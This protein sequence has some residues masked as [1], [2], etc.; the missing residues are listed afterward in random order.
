[1]PA[2]PSAAFNDGAFERFLTSAIA[3]ILTLIFSWQIIIDMEH[4]AVKRLQEGKG[5]DDTLS[6]DDYRNKKRARSEDITRNGFN[7]AALLQKD[8]TQQ[9][10]GKNQD[11]FEDDVF[12][13][14]S[15]VP[16]NKYRTGRWN[17]LHESEANN[18][19][20]RSLS[21]GEAEFL[22]AV[23]KNNELT[24]DEELSSIPAQLPLIQVTPPIGGIKRP[25][26]PYQTYF[27]S[28]SDSDADCELMQYDSN[29]LS[30]L[31]DF[32]MD[33]EDSS[34]S[35][36]DTEVFCRHVLE[37]ISEGDEE[38]YESIS[39]SD[40]DE[41]EE[42]VGDHQ[43][44]SRKCHD[45]RENIG[46]NPRGRVAETKPRHLLPDR[47]PFRNL[48]MNKAHTN[49]KFLTGA[50]S[51][52]VTQEDLMNNSEMSHNL[53]QMKAPRAEEEE[54]LFE[55]AIYMN[56]DFD[57]NECPVEKQTGTHSFITD[58]S[59]NIHRSTPIED[60][61]RSG[62][63]SPGN[64]IH[65]GC[66]SN[67]SYVD[68]DAEMNMSSPFT[69][70][71]ISRAECPADFKRDH[72]G[73]NVSDM[74]DSTRPAG[75]LTSF[76]IGRHDTEVSNGSPGGSTDNAISIGSNLVSTGST[77]TSQV[78]VER[79]LACTESPGLNTI[80]P[81]PSSK[82]HT[83]II[84]RN[85]YLDVK[86][87]SMNR[88]R[89]QG[90]G[91]SEDLNP[92]PF[93]Q[94]GR[95]G[96]LYTD[97][98]LSD[99]TH[100]IP[101]GFTFVRCT[102]YEEDYKV[103]STL[104]FQPRDPGVRL[105]VC[106]PNATEERHQPKVIEV[107]V[108]DI[109]AILSDT[110]KAKA[111]LC[112]DTETRGE[113]VWDDLG[114]FDE[115]TPERTETVHSAPLKFEIY[116]RQPELTAESAQQAVDFEPVIP[117]LRAALNRPVSDNESD[118][119]S[120]S[121]TTGDTAIEVIN[122]KLHVVR[123]G[124]VDS[125]GTD[126]DYVGDILDDTP[127]KM[128]DE[129]S[130][131][132]VKK[133][134]ID[135]DEEEPVF[136]NLAETV[137]SPRFK[138]RRKFKPREDSGQPSVSHNSARII[139]PYHNDKSSTT[140][141]NAYNKG[142]YTPGSG[143]QI[144]GVPD[145][146][147]DH[148]AS[149]GEESGSNSD[150]SG[151]FDC[152]GDSDKSPRGFEKSVPKPKL[153][154]LG[155]IEEE[156]SSESSGEDTTVNDVKRSRNSDTSSTSS[157][158]DSSS[159]SD[160]YADAEENNLVEG[161]RQ[162]IENSSNIPLTQRSGSRD[163]VN[164]TLDGRY[165]SDTIGPQNNTRPKYINEHTHSEDTERKGGIHFGIGLSAN[166]D[167]TDN[168][169]PPQGIAVSTNN[170]ESSTSSSHLDNRNHPKEARVTPLETAIAPPN[171]GDFTAPDFSADDLCAETDEMYLRRSSG[172][173]YS[174][175][176][177]ELLAYGRRPSHGRSEYVSPLVSYTPPA[178]PK[179]EPK[180][181]KY[182][183]TGVQ[184]L[185]S[186]R[187]PNSCTFN[188][189]RYFRPSDV[190][191]ITFTTMVEHHGSNVVEEH[192]YSEKGAQIT[193][194]PLWDREDTQLVASQD[195]LSDE[196]NKSSDSIDAD[197]FHR[198][199]GPSSPAGIPGD[200]S[201]IHAHISPKSRTSS[202]SSSEFDNFEKEIEITAEQ[203]E[204]NF[205]ANEEFTANFKAP[206]SLEED[207][208][209]EIAPKVKVDT[210]EEVMVSSEARVS[211]RDEQM[212]PPS[213]R[214]QSVQRPQTPPLVTGPKRN[215]PSVS[216]DIDI[217]NDVEEP[218]VAAEVKAVESAPPGGESFNLTSNFDADDEGG[219]ESEAENKPSSSLYN[220]FSKPR[221]TTDGSTVKPE[222]PKKPLGLKKPD[223]SPKETE[224]S[225]EKPRVSAK[226]PEI[227]PPK[228][229]T[230]AKPVI[231][232]PVTNVDHP[233]ED[234]KARPKSETDKD[235]NG[236]KEYKSI[237]QKPIAVTPKNI[238]H[239][240]SLPDKIA[241]VDR[242]EI[243]E[244]RQEYMKK[245]AEPGKTN[246]E[247]RKALLSRLLGTRDWS[248]RPK[249]ILKKPSQ[250]FR[251]IDDSKREALSRSLSKSKEN[252]VGVFSKED[253]KDR[254]SAAVER[255]KLEDKSN[256]KRTPLR[257]TVGPIACSKYNEEMLKRKEM[258]KSQ[259][260]PSGFS[261]GSPQIEKE[262]SKS[263]D[264]ILSGR[265]STLP[266]AFSVVLV[267]SPSMTLH[268]TASSFFSDRKSYTNLVETD[269]DTGEVT[270][271]PLVMET[272][273]DEVLRIRQATMPPKCRSLQDLYSQA[274]L[275]SIVKDVY[276]DTGTKEKKTWEKTQS[277]TA[278]T[279]L[280]VSV[281][282][283]DADDE[284]FGDCDEPDAKADTIQ[285]TSSDH[286]MRITKSL[287]KLDLPD[288]YF[289]CPPKP[290]EEK[291]ARE[292]KVPKFHIGESEIANRSRTSS[293]NSSFS[294]GR[295]VVISTRVTMPRTS[296]TAPDDKA[297]YEL[298]SQKIK[299]KLEESSAYKPI[300]SRMGPI[301]AV[302]S[303]S[304]EALAEKELKL[305]ERKR[306]T[307]EFQKQKWEPP[308]I[309]SPK[310][311]RVS[312]A[313]KVRVEPETGE[314]DQEKQQ[315]IDAIADLLVADE[316][317]V[318][319]T[320]PPAEQRFSSNVS[321][322]INSA[323]PPPV[324]K[325]HNSSSESELSFLNS[326]NH[327]NIHNNLDSHF[328]PVHTGSNS[329][330]DSSFSSI[331]PPNFDRALA[332]SSPDL[333]RESPEPIRKFQV[334]TV[335]VA[336]APPKS[337]LNLSVPPDEI[338]SI[339]NIESIVEL[340][341]EIRVEM[342]TYH[343]AAPVHMFDPKPVYRP[344]Q[345]NAVVKP[346][347]E[348]KKVKTKPPPPVRKSSRKEG[349]ISPPLRT[350][351]TRQADRS[352]PLRT[353]S[354]RQADTSPPLRTSSTRQ[355]DRS[356][357]LR[358][359]SRKEAERPTT[360]P[361]QPRSSAME[362]L[363]PQRPAPSRPEIND[364][365]GI[366]EVKVVPQQTAARPQHTPP[367]AP[368]PVFTKPVQPIYYQPNTSRSSES[369]ASITQDISPRYQAPPSSSVAMVKQ[370]PSSPPKVEKKQEKKE[371]KFSFK[372]FKPIVSRKP[373]K[374]KS[375]E[376]PKRHTAE[377][378]KKQRPVAA[379]QQENKAAEPTKAPL[380]MSHPMNTSIESQETPSFRLA[381]A[382]GSR[383]NSYRE[384]PVDY[385]GPAS[386]RSP[387][388]PTG[389][390][391]DSATYPRTEANQ[392]NIRPEV[393]LRR[394]PQSTRTTERPYTEIGHHPNW[395]PAAAEDLRRSFQ[396]PKVNAPKAAIETDSDL[397]LYLSP[398]P[399][400]KKTPTETDLDA[401]GIRRLPARA[402][403]ETDIDSD[404]YDSPIRKKGHG[405]QQVLETN[406]DDDIPSRNSSYKNG[407]SSRNSSFSDREPNRNTSREREPAPSLPPRRY[408]GYQ[409]EPVR[410]PGH[411]PDI[412]PRWDT[413]RNYPEKQ[414]DYGPAPN[415]PPRKTPTIPQPIETDIDA[416]L[417]F[418][419]D[420]SRGRNRQPAY[421]SAPV[422]NNASYYH[423]VPGSRDPSYNQAQVQPKREDAYQKDNQL[424][425]Q[426]RSNQEPPRNKRQQQVPLYYQNHQQSDLF[427]VP[428]IPPREVTKD[429]PPPSIHNV[430]E[431]FE[432]DVDFNL[433]RFETVAV[434]G[435]TDSNTPHGTLTRFGRSQ[436]P[437]PSTQQPRAQVK[438]NHSYDF[439]FEAPSNSFPPT[440]VTASNTSYTTCAVAAPRHVFSV[441]ESRQ[442]QNVPMET[443]EDM[444]FAFVVNKQPKEIDSDVDIL[445]SPRTQ[446][447]RGS[448]EFGPDSFQALGK[449]SD[450][451]VDTNSFRFSKEE[452]QFKC[453]VGFSGATE[454]EATLA[455]VLDGLL[456]LPPSPQGSDARVSSTDS[457]DRGT[458][459]SIPD[460]ANGFFG[461][462][463]ESGE[464]LLSL[465]KRGQNIDEN[466][467]KVKCRNTNCGKEM[468]LA[469]ARCSYKTCH[470]CYT[471]YCCRQ[472]R[473]NDW[474][475]HKTACS[476]N[477][478]VSMCKHAIKTIY[479]DPNILF[480]MSKKAR[481]G[482]LASGRGCILLVF[483]NLF[484]AEQFVREGQAALRLEPVYCSMTELEE[485]YVLGEYGD[486][487]MDMCV[488]YSPYLNFIV[489]VAIVMSKDTRRN[490]G[491]PKKREGPVIKKCAKLCLSASLSES[492]TVSTTSDQ[493]ALI[494]TVG[495]N[496]NSYLSQ[497]EAR[498]ESFDNVQRKLR[499]R[500]VC[501]RE[502][503]PDV[504]NQLIA[505]V[506]ENQAFPQITIYPYD[507]STGSTFMC[508]I[509]LE[510]E[511]VQTEPVCQ[512]TLDTFT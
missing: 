15:T 302:L 385:Q 501:L 153:E 191:S 476:Y 301:D 328:K 382:P 25:L 230:F 243:K 346:M 285:R 429:V 102:D 421:N 263:T 235:E 487:V 477:R 101:R 225:R 347:Q 75:P 52:N 61:S 446:G 234:K 66:H 56:K 205:T 19:G 402:I 248:D 165:G 440:L 499:Q 211:P 383:Q 333:T 449:R 47:A 380:S 24:F 81:S 231:K 287:T 462:I 143:V 186:Y 280:S 116:N 29:K 472:C 42:Q 44:K 86:K 132:R 300:K 358:T 62:E 195:E 458:P 130:L 299:K 224:M 411:I 14:N 255:Q 160:S 340:E 121:T 162:S 430:D 91:E 393:E 151:S 271:K 353:S 464:N 65:L 304:R 409:A 350:S 413:S 182:T 67:V 420:G 129:K 396:G 291:P 247:E 229:P 79:L 59:R 471:Y 183:E 438:S 251:E 434:E 365:A 105:N 43:E 278:L 155:E 510:Q 220:T 64:K 376:T 270:E 169:K 177:E 459:D 320:L 41:D 175:G 316:A 97:S 268:R 503:Y 381:R 378:V 253:V 120:S 480:Q 303:K 466:R 362:R 456:A 417:S 329:D 83:G 20:D 126:E 90:V 127:A 386:P 357:P 361:M 264:N 2:E 21:D 292:S 114:K 207:F 115:V 308:V 128:D 289:K 345:M 131:N 432:T 406:I 111:E 415:I 297:G 212:K 45:D 68:A 474:P 179:S 28:D 187:Q 366:A 461:P 407:E 445:T 204:E 36:S 372:G 408:I 34:P 17:N 4:R 327:P 489:S 437:Q 172:G 436:M 310:I 509:K 78:H 215:T 174:T 161:G 281:F 164:R 148:N 502:Q 338:E 228:P 512:I 87:P 344:V 167:Q 37:A 371:S 125:N 144:L 95:V 93:V 288:W 389:S 460:N 159:D 423:N 6:H 404:L 261:F 321:M 511:P 455:E 40:S 307:A 314:L 367:N 483:Q 257:A 46:P 468:V 188:P 110:R 332:R 469:Q 470:S 254:I 497:H 50:N 360:L 250:S 463:S 48:P 239:L 282:K 118:N 259:T 363:M 178:Q 55:N 266:R 490:S 107:D 51:T 391:R 72:D 403:I 359:S 369:D 13:G 467:V 209:F 89:G 284:V 496:S 88:I 419:S 375:P 352:P 252:N 484:Q 152:G 428:P 3:T 439:D 334:E 146:E 193:F 145:R 8:V 31:D 473:I 119:D 138:T 305:A 452:E 355:A 233:A 275:K 227:S 482:Y 298:P 492:V 306:I 258:S 339:S 427:K 141:K 435:D 53:S 150:S 170:F 262:A 221:D 216:V 123:I 326:K 10:E 290:A 27:G 173:S 104:L 223:V 416:D 238:S 203:T 11:D 493:G 265:P 335:H 218:L 370:A 425:Q 495:T 506:N 154:A 286:Q 16:Q 32:Y 324:P 74:N 199:V 26:E 30:P 249:P 73:E 70:P 398:E 210:G 241:T 33:Y 318:A 96:D 202:S 7:D 60:T 319:M 418:S 94:G 135:V 245:T 412:P 206:I 18:F 465:S 201:P 12:L 507:G 374:S 273:L 149:S 196:C 368:A 39:D 98:V 133:P 426:T 336:P 410:D 457:L 356:P 444:L 443:E 208:D 200:Q 277:L 451:K 117:E 57:M 134:E 400:P 500:G 232:K 5:Q 142:K 137:H 293:I 217:D 103:T 364:S 377:V 494:L 414:K 315:A 76:H 244:A 454:Q 296:P 240:I 158:S 508:V 390:Y 401:M 185:R 447:N 109:G 198:P 322:S 313:A 189:E 405:K 267:R 348:P 54:D 180:T 394:H 478:V 23:D 256:F 479:K 342:P 272:D 325:G 354:T 168:S 77:H 485:Y 453:E 157:G 85:Y 166:L 80:Q 388:S 384:S 312:P 295:P 9:T 214:D 341:P 184:T 140:I 481:A 38:E 190:D 194:D 274:G 283:D 22:K 331:N 192:E 424:K 147:D 343:A 242:S 448:L 71:P 69:D 351:S 63:K 294:H 35:G 433:N 84:S 213:P 1:M 156:I 222:K 163:T 450:L 58:F 124:S 373:E 99:G 136:I 197:A 236:R 337:S 498:D 431:L 379:K 441:N 504:F 171:S 309:K 317:P 486:S 392:R 226:K 112:G 139:P 237:L 475:K 276:D 387:K 395:R 330:N 422:Q 92:P 505:Y 323:K 269:I 176:S 488:D 311:K 397:S 181:P 113:T 260:L 279:S 491:Q 108:H 100:D 442:S 106:N 82:D 349:E 399:S 246:E 122:P 49:E 219:S